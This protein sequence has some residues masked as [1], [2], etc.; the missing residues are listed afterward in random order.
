MATDFCGDGKSTSAL[1]WIGV[2]EG[3]WGDKE[4]GF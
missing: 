2:E 3:G 4:C 1:C